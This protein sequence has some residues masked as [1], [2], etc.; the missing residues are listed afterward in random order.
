MI[1]EDFYYSVDHTFIRLF[2]FCSKE[3]RQIGKSRALAIPNLLFMTRRVTAL[4]V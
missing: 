4:R 1:Y 3:P 2:R